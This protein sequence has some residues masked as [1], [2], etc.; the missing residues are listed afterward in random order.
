M[1]N[2]PKPSP[3]SMNKSSDEKFSY[4]INY[5]QKLVSETER[6]LCAFKNKNDASVKTVKD[7][8]YSSGKLI[9]IYT[10]GSVKKITL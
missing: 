9:V 8:S 5:L 10:D 4:I 6:I 2:L 1:L 3:L 7:I